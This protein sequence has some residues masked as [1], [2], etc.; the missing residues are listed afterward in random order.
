MADRFTIPAHNDV[1]LVHACLGSWPSRLDVHHHHASSTTLDR[2][3]LKTEAEIAAR[4]MSILLQ[5]RCNTLN[6]RGRNDE[7]APARSENRHANRPACR[8]DGKTTFGAL[9]HTQIKF[10]PRI[11]LAP[12]Q[13]VPGAGTARHHAKRG[14]WRAIFSTH[15]YSERANSDRW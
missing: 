3:K 2:D 13:G 1:A 4:N 5:P 12:T 14:G 6:S 8:I 11:D 10:D 7:N 15:C 9:P